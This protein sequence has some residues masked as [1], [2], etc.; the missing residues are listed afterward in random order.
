MSLTD[1]QRTISDT[2][3]LL[4]DFVVAAASLVAASWRT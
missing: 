2:A 3:F 4:S 1:F